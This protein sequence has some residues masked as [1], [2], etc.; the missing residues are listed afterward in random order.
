MKNYWYKDYFVMFERNHN[1]SISA[2]ASGDRDRFGMCF[3]DYTMAEIKQRIN[4][5]CKYRHDNN[6][7]N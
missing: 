3:Y 4:K 6:I 1:G 7:T 2:V 5:Q